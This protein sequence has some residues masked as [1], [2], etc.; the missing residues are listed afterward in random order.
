[1]TLIMRGRLR[2]A[3]VSAVAILGAL[4]SARGAAAD[5]APPFK[6][7]LAQ[8][9]GSAPRL[10]E[11][12]A[13]VRQAEGLARQAGARPNPTA[14]VTIENFS[15]GGVY[16]GTNNAE[17]T[18]QLSQPLEVGGKRGA[19]VAAGRA[20]LDAARARLSQSKAD[21]AFALADAYAQ[22]EA[23]ERRVTLAEEAVT[24]SDETLRASRALVDAGKEAELRTLQA[25][26]A[27]TAARATL[28]EAR[29]ER[30]GAFARLTALAGSPTPFT[31]LT[32]SL[33]V[34]TAAPVQP[35]DIDVL[36]TPAVLAAEA[37]REA[38]ARRVRIEKT[39]AVPD[40]TVSA[41]V[42]RFSGD[43]ST[44]LVAGVSIPIPVFDQNRGNITAAQG[45]LQAAE[46]RLNAARLDAEADIRTA[47]F[48]LG[49]AQSRA[50]AAG[51]GETSAVEAYR[52]T[53][54]A[55]ESGKAPLVELINARRSLAE[56]R[57]LT[58]QAQ[59]ARVRAEADLARL[60]GRLF[61]DR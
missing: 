19:R 53:R 32:D 20:A 14:G 49:A 26:A 44:A 42:R 5:P 39:R 9:Q 7:L 17:T 41:G 60:Q 16:S 58:I 47:R 21:F 27:L 11:A 22:A 59:L 34:S 52:L 25:Q 40:V 55:Y 24:L 3:A 31:E 33:L 1:M 13:G 35:G 10:A 54:I 8:A 51:E 38:A 56:A 43:D 15:G 50:T 37:D 6:A 57:D 36:A 18:F 23:G 29:A 45:E 61:G 28:E 48:Q 2:F 12:A 46:A 30:T 4:A